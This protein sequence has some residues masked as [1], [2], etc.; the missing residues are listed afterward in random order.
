MSSHTH[1]LLIGLFIGYGRAVVEY[2]QYVDQAEPKWIALAINIGGGGGATLVSGT[3]TVIALV[4]DG[5]LAITNPLGCSERVTTA[6][7][8]VLRILLS[9]P[10]AMALTAPY[11][12]AGKSLPVV[13]LAFSYPHF[14]IPVSLLLVFYFRIFRS[15]CRRRSKLLSLT[16]SISAMTLRQT[17]EREKKMASTSLMILILFSAS[18]KDPD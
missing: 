5:Y 13:L 14:T 6:R 11:P 9:L 15:L 16:A 4:L 18:Y 2:L 8:V 1:H 12:F 10:P 7:R 3:W 17:L